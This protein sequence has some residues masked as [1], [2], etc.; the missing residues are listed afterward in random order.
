MKNVFDYTLDLMST[1]AD[2]YIWNLDPFN[3]SFDS[4]APKL[5]GRMDMGEDSGVSLDEWVVA[6]VLWQMSKRFPDV[7]IRCVPC[8]RH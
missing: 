5:H 7:I 1:W 2:N 8:L 6:G 4:S 3:L